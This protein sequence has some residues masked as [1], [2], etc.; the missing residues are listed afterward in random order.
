MCCLKYEQEAYEDLLKTSPKPESFVDTPEGRGTVVDV[1]LLRQSVKVRME[2]Q[3]ETIGCFHNCEICVLRNGKARKNDPPIPADLAPISGEGK[4]P[5]KALAEAE[6][7]MHLDPIRFRYRPD[8]IV[9]EEQPREDRRRRRKGERKS[10]D[11]PK[12]LPEELPEEARPKAGRKARKSKRPQQSP[13]EETTTPK[14][15]P[16]KPHTPKPR[17]EEQ[18][19]VI[20]ALPD[21]PNQPRRNRRRRPAHPKRSQEGSVP[22]EPQG[23]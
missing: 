9:E 2:E 1:N 5:K 19:D 11:A 6:P 20:N 17:L 23:E 10:E 18:L 13:A 22:T 16:K 21:S 15:R 8:D 14:P 12:P 3:P 7:P 4:R